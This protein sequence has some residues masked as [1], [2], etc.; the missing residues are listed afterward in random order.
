[1]SAPGLPTLK[2]NGII[3]LTTLRI[4]FVSTE[5]RKVALGPGATFDSFDFPLTTLSGEAFNQPIFGANNLTGTVQPIEGMGLP[6]PA[7]FKLSF[8]Q[9]GCGSFLHFFLRALRELRSGSSGQG[10]GRMA[11]NG[12][13]R[14]ESSA[15]VDPNDPSII[16]FSQPTVGV[17]PVA[18]EAY[19]PL[20]TAIVVPSSTINPPPA[21]IG[22]TD[23][24]L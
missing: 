3:H 2:S 13:L 6:G 17:S 20:A 11:V 14:V 4:I 7:S 5:K 24:A 12:T 1:V 23:T 9:G 16:Y 22:K 15:F 8:N 10:L 18:A 21:A 19:G